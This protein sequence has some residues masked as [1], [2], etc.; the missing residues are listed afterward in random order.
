MANHLSV[1]V[2]S[3]CYEL[4]DLRASIRDFL[5]SL[6]MNPQLSEDS[7]FPRQSGD[8]PHVVCLRA[9]AECPLVIGLL[10]RRCGQPIADWSPFIEFNGLRP[11]QAELRYAIKTN[12]KL[13][14][15]IH[16]S[17]L[18]AYSIWSSDQ[19]GYQNLSDA[20]KPEIGV[21][22]L[23][24]EL[25]TNDPAPYYETF[26]DASDVISSLKKNLVNEIYTSLREQEAKSRNQ[27]EYLMAQ[28]LGAA[29]EIR[30]R[31]EAELNPD[32]SAKLHQLET[33][34]SEVESKLMSTQEASQASLEDL[35]R[36][37]DLLEALRLLL[38]RNKRRVP[39]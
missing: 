26:S 39:S 18:A 3:G 25:K 28:I 10:E 19:A 5:K 1:F 9:L 16:E 31:I 22:E 4:R 7:G 37:K 2:S 20:H 30:R 34:L 33:N 23:L 27:A 8:K 14:L 38:Y 29:P 21:L 11:T 12:K 35:R 13:L 24:H 17:T 15:Y 36:E 6:G 32:L